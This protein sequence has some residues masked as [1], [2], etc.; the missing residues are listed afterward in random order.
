MKRLL[1]VLSVALILPATAH[2]DVALHSFDDKPPAPPLDLETPGG[3]RVKISDLR[4]KVVVLNFWATWCAPCIREMPALQRMSEAL[5][6][7]GV[8]VFAVNTGQKREIVRKFLERYEIDLPIL[9]DRDEAVKKSWAV[10][11]MPTTY[12]IDR[13]GRV[14]SGAIGER[15]WDGAEIRKILLALTGK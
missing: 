13:Q 14:V 12:V 1:A 3:E 11:V 7:S 10:R 4:G 6:A 2:S 5:F 8:R 9:L 15:K